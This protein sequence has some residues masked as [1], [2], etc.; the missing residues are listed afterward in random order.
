ME[1]STKSS[2]D[3][4]VVEALEST[5]PH[6]ARSVRAVL[7]DIEQPDLITLAQ[8]R[9]LQAIAAYS[10]SGTLN[11]T[12]ARQ[13]GVAAPS[14]TAMV[15]GLVERGLVDRTIDPNNRRQVIIRLTENGI[16]RLA[17]LEG[18]ITERISTALAVL[19]QDQKEHLLSAL[20]DLERMLAAM[21][22]GSG[23]PNEG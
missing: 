22:D 5:I 17:T 19:S 4:R 20:R 11:T 21:P 6:Y 12:L 7:D 14:M 15:D 9:T 13:L 2:L 8:L 23:R 18:A 3:R 1:N 10:E 16:S